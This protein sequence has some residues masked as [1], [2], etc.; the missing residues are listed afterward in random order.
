MPTT[1]FN[2]TIVL[3]I[4]VISASVATTIFKNSSGAVVNEIR[5]HSSS[6]NIS[7]GLNAGKSNTTGIGNSA[8]G[9]DALQN[10]TT[11]SSN[12]A[13]GS[14]AGRYIANKSTPA[15]ILNNSVMLG[16]RT[17]PLADNQTNQIVIGY[18]AI[19]LG[20][21]STVIG[22][23]ST[24]TARVYGRQLVNTSTDNGIDQLQVNGTISA[25]PATLPNQ[26]VTKR[27]WI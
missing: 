4:K 14:D 7:L 19:G 9:T 27:N 17:S 3:S 25:S 23:S 15:T 5:A 20:S 24:T 10:N 22:N 1:D 18:D 12:N 21:N 11:G 26:V 13:I 2:G 16:Y 8:V 6:S